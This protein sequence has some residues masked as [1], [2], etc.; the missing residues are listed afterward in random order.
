MHAGHAAR[1]GLDVDHVTPHPA[2][3]GYVDFLLGV[4]WH[5]GLGET[6]TAMTPCMRLYAFLGQ[7]LAPGKVPSNSYRGWIETY[8]APEM[9]E[10]AATLEGMLDRFAADEP[11]TEQLYRRAME[12]ELAFFDAPLEG[13]TS[14]ASRNRA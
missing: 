5:R 8:S 3:R 1:L 2:T 4:A 10:L 7:S 14:A 13:L 6:V 9:E 11:E 12:H